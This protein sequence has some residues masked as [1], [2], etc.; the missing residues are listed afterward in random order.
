MAVEAAK[1]ILGKAYIV[2]AEF[3]ITNLGSELWTGGKNATESGGAAGLEG[4]RGG[5]AIEVEDTGDSI[6]V[7]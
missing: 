5:D 7:E 4:G 2:P 6:A 3:D 1:V